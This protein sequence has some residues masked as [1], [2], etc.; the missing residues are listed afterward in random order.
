MYI[1]ISVFFFQVQG[2]WIQIVWVRIT[3]KTNYKSLII[4]TVSKCF[5]I[6]QIK[7]LKVENIIVFTSQIL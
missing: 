3:Y 2:R 5:F 7:A 4:L 1:L 6:Y